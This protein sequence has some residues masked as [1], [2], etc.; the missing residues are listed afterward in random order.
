MARTPHKVGTPAAAEFTVFDDTRTEVTGINPAAFE[1]YLTKNGVADATAVTITERADGTYTASFTPATTGR[2][3][4]RVAH[5]TYA[6]AG[7]QETYDVTVD[8]LPAVADIQSGLATSAGLA[9]VAAAI[10]SDTVDI[11]NRLP[12]ALVGGKIAAD[13]DAT[14]ANAIADAFLDRAAAIDGQ[15]PRNALKLMA[16]VLAGKVSGSGTALD[17]YVFLG[18]DGTSVRVTSVVTAAGV[19]TSETYNTA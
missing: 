2:W 4:L 6:P 9:G 3:R 10:L 19:R 15:T 5:P 16:A 11:R 18:L 14:T 7:W 17:P 1:T 13:I 12:A 8:G